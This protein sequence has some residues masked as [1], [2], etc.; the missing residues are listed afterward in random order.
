MT[1]EALEKVINGTREERKYLCSLSFGLFAIYYFQHYFKY[2][3]ADY[4]KDYVTDIENLLDFELEELLWVA[5]REGAKTSFAKIA[6]CWLICY[7]RREYPNIDSFDKENAER[8]LFDVAFEL[9]NNK[10]I[11]A[12]FGLLFSKERGIGD[13]KQNRIN[14]FIT[15]NGIRV[16]AHSTQESVRGRLHLNKRPDFLL[17]DDFENNKTKTSQAYTKQIRDHITEAMGGLGEKGVILYLG[18]YITEYGNVQ[19]IMDRAKKSEKI[20]VR[21]TP[22]VIDGK[23]AWPSKYC[24]TDEESKITG[25]KSIEGMQRQFGSYVFSYEFM[26]TPIDDSMSEFKKDFIQHVE[27][28]T[29]RNKDTSCYVTI[30]PAIS[31]KASADFTGVTINWVDKENKWYLKT[32]KLKLNSK[33]IIDHLFYIQK[34]YSPTFLGMEEVAFTMAIQPF[35]EDEMRKQQLFFTIT[36]IKHNK[37]NKAERIRGLIPRWESRSIFLIGDSSELLDEMRTFP[38]GQHDDVLDSLAMQIHNAKVPYRKM[39]PLGMGGIEQD[40]NEAI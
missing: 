1:P 4:Q 32:Y 17:I 19:W 2:E 35:L 34:T 38:H 33:G 27:M 26:N 6:L 18:N 14:N 40:R 5:F 16:E 24:L 31:E 15:E 21:N 30:D 20:R 9:T 13:V 11:R 12:D 10:R 8:I 23:P 7:K 3:L 36:P 25:K 39:Y 22:I 28:E 37:I 29:V